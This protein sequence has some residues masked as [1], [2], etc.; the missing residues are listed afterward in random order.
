MKNTKKGKSVFA[1]YNAAATTAK[2]SQAQAEKDME[3]CSLLQTDE[4]MRCEDQ[5]LKIDEE[6]D[7]LKIK[8][9]RIGQQ[10]Y[11]LVQEDPIFTCKGPNKDKSK[12]PDCFSCKLV[13]FQKESQMV[14]CCFCGHANCKDCCNK[15]RFYPRAELDKN[16]EKPRGKICRLCDRKFLIRQVLLQTSA[17]IQNRKRTEDKLQAEMDKLGQKMNSVAC[18]KNI[19]TWHLQDQI[20]QTKLQLDQLIAKNTLLFIE[21]DKLKKEQK[22]KQAKNNKAKEAAL[23]KERAEQE[24]E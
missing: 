4:S 22:E 18:S 24:A 20:R 8:Q 23:A 5:V 11:A 14:F 19:K 10:S 15:S 21:S 16:G 13:T 17:D 9:F 6:I 7:D 2:E 1:Q 12:N 3:Q